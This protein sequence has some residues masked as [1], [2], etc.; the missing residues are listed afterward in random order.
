MG[1]ESGTT[2]IRMWS[3]RNTGLTIPIPVQAR[4]DKNDHIRLTQGLLIIS[5]PYTVYIAAQNI[6]NH[7]RV[8][9]PLLFLV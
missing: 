3:D 5:V 2:T 6:R 9:V 8:V 4:L 7:K 1:D